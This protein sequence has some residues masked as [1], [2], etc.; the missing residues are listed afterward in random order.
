L[1]IGKHAP[2]TNGG[3]LRCPELEAPT[4]V[5]PIKGRLRAR[6]MSAASTT[7][8]HTHLI[9]F[10]PVSRT[11]AASSVSS[12]RY[13]SAGFLSQPF[14]RFGKAQALGQHNELENVAVLAGREIKPRAFVVVDKEVVANPAIHQ[15]IGYYAVLAKRSFAART[16]LPSSRKSSRSIVVHWLGDHGGTGPFPMTPINE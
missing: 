5:R 9:T 15:L 8:F 16:A 4:P 2:F 11:V 7:A 1:L 3:A 13:G 12:F 14:R 10:S 6:P